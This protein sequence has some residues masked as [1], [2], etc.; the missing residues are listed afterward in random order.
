MLQRVVEAGRDASKGIDNVDLLV[1]TE[2][3]RI[4]AHAEEI[5]V[6]CVM[7]SA[8]C[9][10]GSDRVLE[11]A[12][13]SGEEYDFLISLQ[14]DVPFVPRAAITNMIE[15]FLENPQIEVV[16]PVIHLSWDALDALRES[17]KK[18]PFS[19]T[20]CIRKDNGRA[21]WFSK[22]IIPGLRKEDKL[23]EASPDKSPVYQHM[24][25]YGYRR[26]VLE[27]FVLW[28]QGH[29]E[30]LEGLEQLRLLENDV[31]IHTVV[32][33]IENQRLQGGIDSPEDVE[34]VER[35]LAEIEKEQ[36]A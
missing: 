29:Y 10:T 6:K 19:G 26:D 7:T 17:K 13:N 8:D 32:T 23:R 2:D 30:K 9:P 33:D 27:K 25:L 14:G 20:T 4:A 11:A 31:H 12:Q 15:A 18:T 16:T 22:N 3:E 28:P 1:T 35:V 34:R 24:G 5:G 21:L 36:A